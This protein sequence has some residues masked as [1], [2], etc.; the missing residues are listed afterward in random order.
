ME[1]RFNVVLQSGICGAVNDIPK[2]GWIPPQ[3]SGTVAYTVHASFTPLLSFNP[4][5]PWD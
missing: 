1:G 5:R 4:I 2:V 3:K